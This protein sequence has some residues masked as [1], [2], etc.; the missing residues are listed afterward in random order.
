MTFI[1]LALCDDPNK[2]C[3]GYHIAC[4]AWHAGRN[5]L[6]R[7]GT[8][9]PDEQVRTVVKKLALTSSWNKDELAARLA[10]VLTDII[11]ENVLKL[12]QY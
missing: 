5:L 9:T 1:S 3:E 7:P 8:Q 2:G 6:S 11:I 4:L 10:Y 12:M